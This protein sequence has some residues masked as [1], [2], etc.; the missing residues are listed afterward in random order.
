[1]GETEIKTTDSVTKPGEITPLLPLNKGGMRGLFPLSIAALYFIAPFVLAMGIIDFVYL[2]Q[3]AFIETITSLLLLIWLVKGRIEG[4]LLI[5][6]NSLNLPL[7]IFI[8]WSFASLLYAHNKYE[9]LLPII[10][11]TSAALLFLL[12]INEV[13]E[14][15]DKTMLLSAIFAAGYLTAVLGIFQHLSGFS[16][17]Y[18]AAP[19]AATFGNKNLAVHFIVLTL[20]ISLPL[21]IN[22]Q[23]KLRPWI[24]SLMWA[25][26]VAFL[27]YTRTRAGWL[28]FL[29]ESIF[30]AGIAVWDYRK[31]G[32]LKYW[33]RNKS[34]AIGTAI[35]LILLMVNFTPEGFRWS[36]GE[37]AGR[38]E[39]IT[40]IKAQ[41]WR[42]GT[43][44]A[45]IEMIKDNPL[46]GVGLGNLKIIYPI[47]HNKV[48]NNRPYDEHQV[49]RDAHNDYLQG[50]AEMGII[51]VLI[52]GWMG[53]LLAKMVP[54]LISPKNS[55][56]TRFYSI[57]LLAG[58][59]GIMVNAFFCFPFE[60]PIPPIVVA[61]FVALL[62]VWGAEGEKGYYKI[63][64]KTAITALFCITLL[65][66]FF[67]ARFNYYTIKADRHFF[68]GRVYEVSNKWDK[69]IIESEDGY[70]INPERSDLLSLAGKGYITMGLYRPA[71]VVLERAIE[72]Y[73]H[74]IAIT[75]NLGVAYYREG[76]NSEA[77]AAF[78]KVLA[79]KPDYANSH[80]YLGRTYLKEGRIEEGARHLRTAVKI[81]P[82]IDPMGNI[83]NMLKILELQPPQ[84]LLQ[85]P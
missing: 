27:I 84:S 64:A 54:R 13:R 34:L 51:G 33:D 30:I 43:W 73:P 38:A 80:Y 3:L 69:A 8:L 70:S 53:I 14:E 75:H 25:T 67:T 17:I 15:G 50:A 24:I 59:G 60:R 61:A 39:S 1:M 81:D 44:K 22:S 21:F 12:I 26:M 66:A 23:N 47:Y 18:Q 6:K 46:I 71:V 36:F 31:T 2:P 41:S 4:E 76:R 42:R 5:S 63:E 65:G 55:Q 74:N 56:D 9:A 32:P 83:R 16:W 57:A 78:E 72:K 58:L 82:K 62:T 40:D 85:P 79:I 7:S 28:A 11:L 68:R 37:V 20:P 52:I 48:P 49:A 29:A 10:H 45:T 19:P 35:L 77:I